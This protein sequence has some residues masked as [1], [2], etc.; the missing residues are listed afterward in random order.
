MDEETAEEEGMEPE[1]HEAEEGKEEE[2]KAPP[3][4]EYIQ[5]LFKDLLEYHS[6]RNKWVGIMRAHAEAEHELEMPQVQHV[7]VHK[8]NLWSVRTYLNERLARFLPN[9]RIRVLP[10]GKGDPAIQRASAI[11]KAINSAYYWMRR[12]N[13]DWGKAIADVLL[14]EGGVLRLEVNTAA[15]WP[16]LIRNEEDGEDD[17]TR[18]MPTG[19]E[20]LE[21]W[22]DEETVKGK[23]G[24]AL[25]ARKKARNEYKKSQPFII[26][27]TYVPLEAY[28][29]SP[30]SDI[31]EECIELEFRSLR[32]VLAN[33]Q[34][35]PEG[36]DSLRRGLGEKKATFKAHVPILRYCGDGIYAYYALPDTL[37]TDNSED[38]FLSKFLKDGEQ[39]VGVPVL[40]YWYE[41]G[42]DRPIYTEIAGMHGGWTS[43]DQRL[44]IGRIKALASLDTKK[45]EAA[46]Q[47]WTNMRETAWPTWKLKVSKN[48]PASA[49]SSQ[50]ALDQIRPGAAQDIV[51][52]EDEDLSPVMQHRE[53]PYYAD[54]MDRIDEAMAKIGGAPG[55]SGIHQ[56]G[57]EG[58]FQENTLLQQAD[59]Q[60]ARI[61]NN[62]VTS[63]QNEALLFLDLIKSIG[64]EV[65][66]R[67]REKDE[68]SGKMYFE[69]LMLS[70]EMLTPR[71]EVDAV[72]KARAVGNESLGLR[73]YASAITDVNGPGTAAMTRNTA[74]ETFLDMEY[75]D[76]EG[77]GVVI[78]RVTDNL[79]YPVL[80]AEIERQ[81]NLSTVRDAMRGTKS[82]NPEEMLQS[83]QELTAQTAMFASGMT[84]QPPAPTVPTNPVPPAPVDQSGLPP[85]LP[86]GAP[87]PEAAQGRA[88]GIMQNDMG[89]V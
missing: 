82:F 41:T 63:A 66:I 16:K 5:E 21:G 84:P 17:I 7:Q 15:A 87:Q 1:G 23:L 39:Q 24:V 53:N 6:T 55:L 60:F 64:E 46:S 19:V 85:G 61:E 56:P 25:A 38:S 68:K 45:D 58:G 50:R 89:V 14:C 81:Y 42:I 83:D 71:P 9:P 37:E 12:K 2:K 70:P 11:E 88:D 52:F 86:P 22:E 27:R 73:N 8:L 33:K 72:V 49:D 30:D 29:P 32:K 51:L 54:I 20:E 47:A 13:D 44:T 10:S 3:E 76:D 75:P 36:I 4:G 26:S 65:F 74:R 59:S 78:E 43:G 28:Y 67:A 35:L 80:Q 57:I 69:E 62:I 34:F 79:K 40:L 18:G 77:L 48:R 31:T